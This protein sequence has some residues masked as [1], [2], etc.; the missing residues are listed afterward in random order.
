MG[1]DVDLDDVAEQ[2]GDT[3]VLLA[4]ASGDDAGVDRRSAGND[5][6]HRQ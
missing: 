5:F 6:A 3:A 2:V 1:V 4:H